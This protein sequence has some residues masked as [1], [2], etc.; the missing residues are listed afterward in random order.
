MKR[1]QLLLIAVFFCYYFPLDIRGESNTLYWYVAASISKVAKEAAEKFNAQ[2]KDFNVIVIAGGSGELI[3]QITLS[4]RGDLFTPASDDFLTII[5]DKSMVKRYVK[6][7]EQ[8]PVFGLAKKYK[9]KKLSFDEL[10]NGDYKIAL[11]NPRTMAIALTFLSIE[12]K[13]PKEIVRKIREREKGCPLDINQSVSYLEINSVDAALIFDT[14][15]R[16]NKLEYVEIPKQYNI[17]SYAYLAVLKSES[18]EKNTKEFIAFIFKNRQI[19]D[20][21]GYPLLGD[22]SQ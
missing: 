6:L 15:A 4:G 8:T 20:K 10:I 18:S 16:A 1:T 11:G 17:D 22:S 21:Y 13:M 14:V 7:L 19:F 12:E 5:K 9:G 2:K 3:S